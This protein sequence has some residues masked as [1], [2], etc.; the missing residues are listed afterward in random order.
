MKMILMRLKIDRR[1]GGAFYIY[2]DWLANPKSGNT[3]ER[4]FNFKFI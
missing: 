1:H 2:L 3:I 4:F